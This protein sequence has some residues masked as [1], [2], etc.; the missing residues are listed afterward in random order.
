MFNP[1]FNGTLIK[2]IRRFTKLLNYYFVFKKKFK[3][4]KKNK[5]QK[6]KNIKLI[7][8]F[9][10]RSVTIRKYKHLL[11]NY[12]QPSLQTI[13]AKMFNFSLINRTH[14]T[15]DNL[16][17]KVWNFL[18]SSVKN[19][20]L[21]LT[22][23]ISKL[24]NSFSKKR[25]RKHKKKLIL[26]NLHRHYIWK[27]RKARY[28]HWDYRKHGKLNEWRYQKLLCEEL[29]II[30]SGRLNQ[31]LNQLFLRLFCFIISWRDT[32]KIFF[33]VPIVFN[34]KAVF[35]N[36]KLSKGDIIELPFGKSFIFF[37]KKFYKFF[38]KTIGLCKKLSYKSYLS[39]KNKQSRIKKYTV[40]PKVF[41]KLPIGFIKL[42]KSVSRDVSLNI[43]AV[44]K[45]IVNI[46]HDIQNSL[47]FSSVL[48]LQTWRYR[49]D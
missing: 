33:K 19:N 41:K 2:K 12:S 48:R 5:R 18:Y 30:G 8:N 10:K 27:L 39:H 36:I 34:G 32:S 44:I 37:K 16:R 6:I 21:T 7:F 31:L 24:A 4:F 20:F 29:Q 28:A 3:H 38:K 49:F 45:P 47:N 13:K 25:Q 22:K 42:G 1:E 26:N 14:L 11:F 23:L 15:L 43:I 9:T 46:T 35:T 40:V 17:K